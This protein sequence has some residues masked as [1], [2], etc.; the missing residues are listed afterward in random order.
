MSV[1]NNKEALLCLLLFS[2]L[3]QAAGATE[4][5]GDII[6]A[7]LPAIGYGSTFYMDD[8]EGREQFY[9]SFATNAAVTFGLK[10]LVN[11]KRPNGE[12]NKSFPSGHTS[13]SFQSATFIQQRY[14]WKYAI[15]AYVAATYVGYSRVESDNH[16]IEDVIAGAAIGSLSSW[17]F[18]QS[19][20][21]FTI[22]P[23]VNNGNYGLMV[24]S[25]W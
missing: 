3:S 14:G 1:F 8:S 24:N 4:T 12:D 22:T 7:L 19:Y 9:Y 15:P 20:D 23:T 25:R 21:G 5:S 18:T 6:T 16:H 2:P 10:E 11:K 17:L 13:I